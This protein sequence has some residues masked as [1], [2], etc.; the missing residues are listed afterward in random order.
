[1]GSI[2]EQMIEGFSQKDTGVFLDECMNTK[3]NV[4]QIRKIPVRY[5]IIAAGF[6]SHM[7]LEDLNQKLEDNGCERLYARNITEASLIYAFQ[8]KNP[9][10]N[11]DGCTNYVKI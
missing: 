1:M 2:F 6:V 8:N 11:G 3:L 5:R 4:K 7:N 10:R 9:M